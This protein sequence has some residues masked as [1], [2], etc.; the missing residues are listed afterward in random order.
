MSRNVKVMYSLEQSSRE[1]IILHFETLFSRHSKSMILLHHSRNIC[2]VLVILTT[3]KQLNNDIFCQ[4][5]LTTTKNVYY[6]LQIKTAEMLVQVVLT[7]RG[8]HGKS[9]GNCW[10]AE[11]L[12]CYVETSCV[13]N[14][15]PLFWHGD[16]GQTS[17]LLLAYISSFFGG[18]VDWER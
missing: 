8:L 3:K 5:L 6:W 2:F 1:W 10:L 18:L 11:S 16:R 7:A 14:K 15:R 13:T 17:C 12:Y 9:A 4:L